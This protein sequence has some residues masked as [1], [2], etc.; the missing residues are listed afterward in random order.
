MYR[1]LV[2]DE[3]LPA[4]LDL[5]RAAPDARVDDLRLSRA[6]LLAQVGDYDALIV[7]SGTPV[8]RPL[9]EAGR[10]L[11]VIGRAGLAL[12]NIDLAAATERGLMVMNTPQAYS[13]AAAEHTL[14][15]MLALC[16]R[17]PAAEA[18][19]RRGEW[20]RGRFLGV[21]L[22]GKM[23]GLVGL[24][25]VGRLVAQRALAFGMAVLVYDPY[26]DDD[27]ARRLGVTLATFDEVL[28]RAD[29]LTLHAEL[30]PETNCLIGPVELARLKPGARLINCARG[31]LVDEAA[32]AEALRGG[33]L[34]GAALDVFA[35]EPPA[36]HPLLDLPN[37]VLTP[38]LGGSTEEAQRETSREIARQVLDALRGHDYR[39]VVN[40]P[41][42]A[43]PAF[44]QTRPYLALAEQIGALQAQLAGGE[45]T[46][47][48]VEV[49]GADVAGLV[50]AVA[51]AL[52]KGLLGRRLSQAVNYVNA[53]LLAAQ[54]GLAIAQAR[55]LETADYAN[56]VSCRVRW[57]GGQRLVAGTLFGGLE[58][59][60]VQLDAFRMDARPQGQVLIMSSRDVPGV[61]GIVGTLLHQYGVNIA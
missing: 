30:T 3:I 8:D 56:L 40:L 44:A 36:P 41:F 53:P 33:R 13:L 45:I 7:R 26:A 4:G 16:R 55:G 9:I 49:K 28:S 37:L 22:H 14:A 24:G 46:S 60:I 38:H 48:E 27:E 54:H 29:Y 34:A 19:L 59:R 12:D 18:A 15:L 21:Q 39:N 50:K 2:A 58:S 42:I 11:R 17:V 25:R 1:I 61:I 5:L 23:L 20:G 52:L 32:L 10:S 35:A 6:E 31:E 43:G 47:V 51:V 57:T